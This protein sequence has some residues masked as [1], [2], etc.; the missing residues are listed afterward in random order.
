MYLLDMCCVCDT[1]CMS[2]ALSFVRNWRS[3]LLQGKR[4]GEKKIRKE[5]TKEKQQQ[6]KTNKDIQL[7]FHVARNISLLQSGFDEKRNERQQHFNR[8]FLRIFSLFFFTC[9]RCGCCFFSAC[10]VHYPARYRLDRCKTIRSYQRI[11][12]WYF[13]FGA[14]KMTMTSACKMQITEKLFF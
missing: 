6:N 8:K 14:T 3:V 4:N 5:F 7:C 13:I 11:F 12:T 1:L 10:H 9:C 2:T